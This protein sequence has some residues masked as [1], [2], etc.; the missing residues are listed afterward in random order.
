MD[1]ID[2]KNYFIRATEYAAIAC[3]Q[4]RGCQDKNKADQAAVN[5]MRTT[6][7]NAPIDARVAI[8]EGE[9]D[10]APMLYIGEKLGTHIGSE[11]VLPIDIAVDPLECTKNCANNAPN[12][13]TV[14]ALSERGH[15]FRAPDTYM[16]KLVVGSACKDVV[17]LD[18]TIEKNIYSIADKTGKPRDELRAIVLE[19]P[20]NQFIVDELSNLGVQIEMIS[21]GDIAASLRV[22]SD[23]ADVYMGI[24]SAPEGVI[25]ATAVKG[26]G[27]F[28][29]GRLH[30]HSDE[31][32]GRALEMSSHSADEKISIDKLC[33]S[34]NSM[35]VATGVC[36][37]WIPGVVIDGDTATTSSLLIDVKNGEMIRIT[38]SYSVNEV[39]EYILEGVK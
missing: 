16:N 13:M 6:L 35:F 22:A 27:G 37:G 33:S 5:G 18:F 38:N 23:E 15:L 25:G 32:K 24:G 11:D 4:L 39:N 2:Y 31:A 1:I 8:G 14:M 3:A 19:R 34:N 36:D 12:A 29:D 21:D 20:R 30:F 26:L 17:S 7:M 10:E 28:F 9:I